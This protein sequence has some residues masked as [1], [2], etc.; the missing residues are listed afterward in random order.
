MTIEEPLIK[1][2][3]GILVVVAVA[4]ALFFF[5]KFG[6]IDF[7]KNI[8]GGEETEKEIQ[9]TESEEPKSILEL[10]RERIEEGKYGSQEEC[11]KEE[12]PSRLCED[13]R[14][15]FSAHNSF[16]CTEKE[17]FKISDELRKFGK[18]CQFVQNKK[19]NPF[20]NKCVTLNIT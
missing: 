15:F 10:C 2:I 12:K 13:C 4:T 18:K 9:H 17:C 3:L 11:L 6:A 5:F 1:I 14:E 7:F 20:D 16:I 8:I 19:N